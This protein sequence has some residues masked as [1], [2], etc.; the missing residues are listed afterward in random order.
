MDS[1]T[2]LTATKPVTSAVAVTVTDKAARHAGR[3]RAGVAG[4]FLTTG[5]LHFLVEKEYTATVPDYLPNGKQLV[6]LSGVAE[7]AGGAGVLFPR[8]RRLAGLGLLGL[9]V[10]VYPANINMA[11]HS[12][13]WPKV[14]A[15]VLWGRLPLQFAAMV[16]VNTASKTRD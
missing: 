11:L 10:A 3:S 5:V 2:E 7:F 6:Y 15:W 16:W 13:R 8:T 14:P 1:A 12:E 4:L 9:L